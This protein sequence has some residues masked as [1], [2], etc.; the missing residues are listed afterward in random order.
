[1]KICYLDAFSG[2]SGDMTVG[3]LLDAGVPADPLLDAL[4]GLNLEADFH[5]E[6]TRRCGVAA[7]QFRVEAKP[8]KSHRHL[9]HI[10]ELIEKSSLSN[11]AKQNTSAVFWRLGQAE[12][13]IHGVPIEKVHFHEVGAVDSIA[14]IAGACAAF[15]LLGVDEIH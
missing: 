8:A 2:I 10:L 13:R 6:K 3:A 11:R 9:H 15:D 5:V 12:A 7:S 4:R 1:M 14:D